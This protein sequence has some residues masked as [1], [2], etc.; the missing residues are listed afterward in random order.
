MRFRISRVVL[1]L[2][3][4]LAPVCG[5]TVE[6]A[7]PAA[8]QSAPDETVLASEPTT[9]AGSALM[10]N[11]LTT[12]TSDPSAATLSS[13]EPRATESA[14]RIPSPLNEGVVFEIFEAEDPD[15]WP[16]PYMKP[17]PTADC[18][19]GVSVSC[20]ETWY[21][22]RYAIS[23]ALTDFKWYLAEYD[24]LVHDCLRGDTIGSSRVLDMLSPEA[25]RNFTDERYRHFLHF[26]TIAYP[27]EVQGIHDLYLAYLL[28]PETLWDTYGFDDAQYSEV[29]AGRINHIYNLIQ[30]L[31]AEADYNLFSLMDEEG[32]YPLIR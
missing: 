2:A 27:Q 26:P 29:K 4:L 12:P 25:L 15:A 7:T 20:G 1:I 17:P 14:I 19:I 32:V 22:A 28:G 21:A 13:P 24:A 5:C 10:S 31:M 6:R 16:P 18:V 11:S 9:T 23:G 8:A 30:R 3:A